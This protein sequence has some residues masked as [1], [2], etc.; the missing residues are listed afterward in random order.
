MERAVVN[1]GLE[2]ACLAGEYNWSGMSM[3]A[4][5]MSLWEEVS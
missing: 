1:S 4:H 2:A 5:R 3:S